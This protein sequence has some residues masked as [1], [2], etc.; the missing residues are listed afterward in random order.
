MEF[1]MH[2]FEVNINSLGHYAAVVILIFFLFLFFAISFY[3]QMHRVIFMSILINLSMLAYLICFLLLFNSESAETTFLLSRLL[4]FTFIIFSVITLLVANIIS[5][6]RHYI[7][8]LIAFLFGFVFMIMLFGSDTLLITR[9]IRYGSYRITEKGP[10]YFLFQL[11]ILGINIYLVVD[12]IVIFV[13]QRHLF[14][15]IWILYF[16][17]IFYA[18]YTNIQSIALENNMYHKPSLYMNSIVFSSLITLFIFKKVKQNIKE[19]ESYYE[20]Y[21]YDELTGVYT[22]TYALEVLSEL[23]QQNHLIN[24]FIAILDI[25]KFK[26]INDRFG[27][28][29]GDIVLTLLGRLLTQ[30]SKES[31]L[32]GRLGGD[33]FIII[34]MNVPKEKVMSLLNDLRNDYIFELTQINPDLLKIK[35]G[36]SIGHIPFNQT[37]SPK[38]ILSR[39]DQAMYIEKALRNI[40]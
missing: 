16:A 15:E 25:D 31:T 29:T 36:L 14:N 27:H 10:L 30:L 20:T 9:T 35:T 22:R 39:A 2:A 8:S 12:I 28:H 34:F 40:I 18:I 1:M 32:C 37:M 11:Y 4:Y 21:L 24:H 5:K 13:K 23:T 33:E 19:H 38:D 17:M 3:I 7:F 6:K 26:Q